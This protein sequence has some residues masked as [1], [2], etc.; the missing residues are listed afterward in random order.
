MKKKALITGISGQDGS[1]LAQLLLGLGYEVHGVIRRSSSINTWRLDHLYEEPQRQGRRLHL[2][3]GDIT[4]FASCTSLINTIG[5]DE[6][7]NLAAQ[8]HVKVSFEAPIYTSEADAVGSIALLEA[9]RLSKKDI[10]IY[11]ASSS[12]MFGS[13]QPPQSEIS[14]LQ[15]R[16]PYAIAKV[17]A[18]HS[19]TLYR[20]AYGMF[21]VSG[22]LFNHESPRRGPTFVTK[23]IVQ[24]LARIEA[25]RQDK[26]FLGNLDS[27]RDWGYAPD[28]VIAM[29]MMLQADSPKDF[30]ISTGSSNTV[31]DFL[32]VSLDMF[33]LTMDKVGFDERYLRPSEVDHLLG[34]SSLARSELGWNTDVALDDLVEIM[35]KHERDSIDRWVPDVPNSNLWKWVLA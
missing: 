19:V 12:E 1:Y 25:G 27:K 20:D 28:Y 22:I 35:M 31:L 21:A 34:N 7:Y 18:H 4:D 10:R 13:T 14:P 32:K 5:P 26:L 23:K 17:F 15:P 11:Q 3:Y 9:I 33:G 16:S 29:W 8:S 2:H 30:V 6:V 24:G